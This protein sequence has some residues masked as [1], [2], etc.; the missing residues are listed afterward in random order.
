MLAPV[1]WPVLVEGLGKERGRKDGLNL[2]PLEIQEAGRLRLFKGAVWA[3][4]AAL[5]LV[6]LT[7]TLFLCS[8]E[9]ILQGEVDRS[10]QLLALRESRTTEEARTV[11]ARVPLLRVKL[12][13][14]R[15]GQAVTGLSRLG[16][17][18]FQPP[19]GIQ[20]EKVEILQLPGDRVTEGFTITG[21][22]FTER[23]FSVGPLAQYVL[24]LNRQAGLT[25]EPVAEATISDR[26]VAGQERHLD[27]LAITRFTL[28]GTFR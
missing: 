22:A 20:L 16:T 12:A 8:Q 21:L 17:W 3:A 27:Q 24:D 1:L 26:V 19:Q 7:G 2:V 25:L 14:Q 4:S 15:Q 13:E 6:F 9:L 11:D 28:K 23:G 10:S 18:I 5:A